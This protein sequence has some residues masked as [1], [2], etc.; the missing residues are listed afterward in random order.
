MEKA[1]ITDFNILEQ[2]FSKQTVLKNSEVRFDFSDCYF[3]VE[4][5]KTN[6]SSLRITKIAKTTANEDQ[7]RVN[8]NCSN[9]IMVL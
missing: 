6:Y 8:P 3:L 2:D 7:I 9:T 5:D 4:Q 1:I